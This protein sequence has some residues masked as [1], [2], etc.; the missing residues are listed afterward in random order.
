MLGLA[1]KRRPNLIS[2][3]VPIVYA[4][5]AREDTASDEAAAN[6]VTIASL[7]ETAKLN[8]INPLHWLTGA[9]AKL[10]NRWSA[11][12]I[13][14]LMPWAYAKKIGDAIYV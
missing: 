3:A 14:G 2:A 4:G 12:R 8:G 10:V 9:L 7:I 6:R 5:G 13:D 11:S 1:R